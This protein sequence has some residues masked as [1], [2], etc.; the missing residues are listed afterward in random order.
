[1]AALQILGGALCSTPQSLA[2]FHQATQANSAVWPQYTNVTDRQ[3]GQRSESDSTG[4]TVLQTV[5]QK[6]GQWPLLV[7]N[8]LSYIS[9]GSVATRF[10]CGGIS[11]DVFITSSRLSGD[12]RI[13]KY[14]KLR[15][16]VYSGAFFNSHLSIALPGSFSASL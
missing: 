15:P 10:T 11:S 7:K 1:M 5:A 9:Q 8:T 4:R 12:E 16:T 13:L 14:V 3:T 6:T 2:V